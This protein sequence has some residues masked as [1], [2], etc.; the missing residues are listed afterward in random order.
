M[1][2]Q[3]VG[4]VGQ[5]CLG[6]A[7]GGPAAKRIGHGQGRGIIHPGLDHQH[8]RLIGAQGKGAVSQLARLGPSVQSGG[9][10][11]PLH[12]CGLII[13]IAFDQMLI[14]GKGLGRVAKVLQQGAVGQARIAVVGVQFKDV[15][16][17]DQ[18]ARHVTLCNQL[19]R[20][21]Q[22]TR[23]PVLG[24]FAPR[25][26]PQRQKQNQNGAIAFQ[27]HG[28][29]PEVISIPVSFNQDVIHPRLGFSNSLGSALLQVKDQYPVPRR[30]TTTVRPK[31]R[32]SL[33]KDRSR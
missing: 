3:A 12:Q 13:G 20:R 7:G 1:Q 24:G 23:R 22:I 10:F 29:F 6:G 27:Y 19:Q 2:H 28:C 25:Q 11:C 26:S 21:L 5:Q 16:K 15:A 18:G 8:R 31:S 33:A 14:L 17:L 30:T 32:R 4:L 9:K